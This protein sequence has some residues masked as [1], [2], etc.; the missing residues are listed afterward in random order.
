MRNIKLLVLGMC[1]SSV[2]VGCSDSYED[3]ANKTLKETIQSTIENRH[4]IV[5]GFLKQQH[6]NQSLSNQFY[7]CFS[8]MLFTKNETLKVGEVLGW[9]N[10]TYKTN[11][12]K[13][14]SYIN[15]DNFEKQFSKWNGSYQPLEQLIKNNMNDEDSYEH[16]KTN[17]RLIL[18]EKNPTAV[19]VT[20]FKGK[21]TYGATVKQIIKAVVSI[22]TGNVVKIIS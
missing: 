6:L 8:E 18:D 9:C 3:S 11:P 16:V 4:E 12:K 20:E 13:M 1:M 2:L 15:F 17:Y 5:D 21:N 14:D 7:N 22:K 19:I 10:T